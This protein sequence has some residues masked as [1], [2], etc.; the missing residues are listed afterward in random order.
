[1]TFNI[2]IRVAV[3]SVILGLSPATVLSAT[4]SSSRHHGPLDSGFDI[5]LPAPVDLVDERPTVIGTVW[6][7]STQT[8]G[9]VWGVLRDNVFSWV[10]PPSA[11]S[12]TQ[13]VSKQDAVQ[14]FKL[15][16][17]AGYKLKEINTDV[18]LIPYLSFKFG[19]AR[20]LS[21]A[22]YDYLE[23]QVE[24]WQRTNPGIYASL[25]RKI[26]DT[27]MTVNLG[28]EYKVS[29]LKVSLLPLP[30]VAFTMSP[31]QTFLGE[32]NSVL[33]Q[34]IQRVER[35]LRFIKERKNMP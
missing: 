28:G 15:L 35:D 27:V 9:W 1:M 19:L 33:M 30:D 11:S 26:I 6:N 24:E 31:K 8:V 7:Y 34:A 21:E 3:V 10:T 18:G 22:D 4:A 16:G 25:Q 5:K 32:E 29:T 13:S 12:L 23:A 2:S 20:E 17:Y 14:L